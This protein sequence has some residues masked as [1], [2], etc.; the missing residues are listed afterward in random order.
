MS[1][2]K[3]LAI[4]YLSMTRPTRS[5]MRSRPVSGRFGRLAAATMGASRRSV[6]WSKASRLRARSA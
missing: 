3:C 6:A 5:A 1:R 2:W 4:L